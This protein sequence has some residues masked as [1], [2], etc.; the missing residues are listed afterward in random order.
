M[1]KLIL[2]AAFVAIA[3]LTAVNASE[4]KINPVV[5]VQDSVIKTPI[6]L[7]E[8]PEAVLNTLKSDPY[9]KWTPVAAFSVKDGQKSYFQIDVKKEEETS[10][11][12]LDKDGKPVE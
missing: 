3:G 5:A 7:E 11:I 8:L 2:S 1:K 9:K 4:V 12:K 10:S 6:K